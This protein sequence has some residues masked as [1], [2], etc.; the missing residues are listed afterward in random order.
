MAVVVADDI[1]VVVIVA[2]VVLGLC[3]IV[4][5]VDFGLGSIKGPV[6]TF[7]GPPLCVPLPY[8]AAE[9]QYKPS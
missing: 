3:A 4:I 2:G 8:V 6:E 5:M 7:V 9:S 1:G